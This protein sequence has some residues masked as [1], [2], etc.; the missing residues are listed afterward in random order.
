M[1][2]NFFLPVSFWYLLVEMRLQ[3]KNGDLL[4]WT[5]VRI[6]FQWLHRSCAAQNRQADYMA[7]NLIIAPLLYCLH[8]FK[9]FARNLDYCFVSINLL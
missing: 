3:M 6:M 5:Y 4:S 7:S 2:G 9:Q 1:S 8:P